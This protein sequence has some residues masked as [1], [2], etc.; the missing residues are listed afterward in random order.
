MNIKKSELN[1]KEVIIDNPRNNRGELT[2]VN[3]SRAGRKEIDY[4]KKKYRFSST[5]LSASRGNVYAQR[6]TFER[7]PDYMF[8]ILQFPK[9]QGGNIEI[10]E[11]EIF[12]SASY[13]IT[14][15]NNS[16]E[17]NDFFKETE[18]NPKHTLAY[19]KESP[20]ILL[21]ELVKKCYS[22]LLM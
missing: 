17:I 15:H 18:K 4:L 12:F 10:K 2:W 11:I 9:L 8:I 7:M 13:L 5:H 1:I 14:I 20:R 3:I 16:K 19:K 6:T 21:Y 22:T